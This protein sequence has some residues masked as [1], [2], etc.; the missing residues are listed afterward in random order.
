MRPGLVLLATV[1]VAAGCGVSLPQP[2]PSSPT[3]A[4]PVRTTGPLAGGRW[5]AVSS[6]V[7]GDTL[8]VDCH[9][10]AVT[11]RVIGL[12]TPETKDPRKPVQCFGP[13]ASAEAARVLPHG[14]VVRLV[15]DPTQDARDRYQRTLAYVML[16]NGTD[17]GLHMISRGFGREYTFRAPYQRQISYKSAQSQAIRA[18]LGLW[19]R[20][21]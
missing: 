17:Y 3:A 6:T 19:G 18:G 11:V 7:D 1:L 14:H 5:C 12:D 16:A 10:Q 4:G 2:A 21:G 15:A 8:H 13:E 20:C 9:G